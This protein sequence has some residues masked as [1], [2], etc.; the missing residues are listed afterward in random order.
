M[1]DNEYFFVGHVMRR[2]KPVKLYFLLFGA[3][4][5]KVNVAYTSCLFFLSLSLYIDFEGTWRTDSR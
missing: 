3:F 5:F 4:L 2:A 1:F